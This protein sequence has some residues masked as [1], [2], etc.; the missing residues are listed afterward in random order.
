MKYHYI[1]ISPPYTLNKDWDASE[2]QLPSG[3]FQKLKNYIPEKESLET[4]K[5]ITEFVF[6]GSITAAPTGNDFSGDPNCVAV[7]RFEN[8]AND[9]IGGNHLTSSGTVVYTTADV[10]EGDYAVDLERDDSAY[11]TITDTNLDAGFPGKKGEAETDFS[12]FGFF[13]IESYRVGGD[14][15]LC[16]KHRGTTAD[17]T[18]GTVVMSAGT[19]QLKIGYNGG[20]AAS[21]L[22]LTAELSL[23][24][25]Y[26]V[27]ATYQA[28]NNR[29]S[30]YIWNV[31]TSALIDQ[32]TDTAAG[33]M[34]PSSADFTIGK[35]G[36]SSYFDG[37]MDEWGVMKDMLT[38]AEMSEIRKG[39]YRP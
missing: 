9:T 14:A 23:A 26:W 17:R 4:R 20:C 16:C 5:G 38:T 36:G 35:F 39:E 24:T 3:F 1:N 12:L 18:F 22:A 31:A 8:N 34:S 15:G 6:T 29:M 13:K 33:D 11:L 27:C 10:S 7:W 37:L 30:M 25:W 2:P 28:S 32:G 19:C 21:T